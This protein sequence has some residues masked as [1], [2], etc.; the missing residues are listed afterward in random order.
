MQKTTNYSYEQL[1]SRVN[2]QNYQ[3]HNAYATKTRVR[4]RTSLCLAGE[5]AAPPAAMA[6]APWTVVDCAGT[7]YL[8]ATER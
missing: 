4:R 1:S 5:P 2:D 6:M 3:N 8:H 7:Q